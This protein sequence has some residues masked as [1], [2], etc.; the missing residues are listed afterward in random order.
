VLKI[1]GQIHIGDAD[2]AS[3]HPIVLQLE[4]NHLTDFPLDQ[5]G[6]A[7]HATCCSHSL[8]PENICEG[9]ELKKIRIFGGFLF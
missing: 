2:H 6:H 5:F 8:L 7:G 9:D 4:Q 3:A 1:A